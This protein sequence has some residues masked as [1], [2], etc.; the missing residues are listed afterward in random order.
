MPKLAVIGAIL[1][2]IVGIGVV[3]WSVVNQ[4]GS[5]P[6][7]NGLCPLE[8]HFGFGPASQIIVPAGGTAMAGCEVPV[9][10]VDY[11]EMIPIYVT[12]SS[13][14]SFETRRACPL[15]STQSPF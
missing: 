10:G 15:R 14:S 12:T 11:C 6:T 1:G 9:S 3:G 5:T 13:L 7:C 2:G 8:S 4:A